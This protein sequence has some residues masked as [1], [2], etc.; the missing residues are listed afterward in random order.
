M[1]KGKL[2]LLPNVFTDT[3]QLDSILPVAYL[4]EKMRETN[5][6]AFE[7]KRSGFRFISK[8]KEPSFKEIPFIELNEHTKPQE[9][10]DI[11]QALMDGK[12]VSIVSDAGLPCLA[13]PGSNLVLFCHQK[14]IKVEHVVGPS[15]I[16][17]ALIMSGLN[18]QRFHFEGYLP[19]EDEDR[20]KRL[21]ELITRSEKEKTTMAF[22]ETPYRNLALFELMNQLLPKKAFI[23]VAM[24]LTLENEKVYTFHPNQFNFDPAI[25]KDHPA[26][27]LFGF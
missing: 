25:L 3:Q 12:V 24:D 7:S 4:K 13:D 9:I 27:F 26:I 2:L 11:K 16:P 6:W 8:F 1:S 17:I 22:I 15:S 18:A 14:N 19:K 10:Q 20:R 23:S 5:L 21:L